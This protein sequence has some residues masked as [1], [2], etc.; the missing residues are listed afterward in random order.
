MNANDRIALTIGRLVMQ[1]EAQAEALE[2]QAN[3]EAKANASPRLDEALV[4]R[5][6]I[7]ERQ[8]KNE[9]FDT[10]PGRHDELP[11]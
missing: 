8:R 7:P 10:A 3:N 2:Q 4:D 1:V 9:M 5:T 11:A 6:Y